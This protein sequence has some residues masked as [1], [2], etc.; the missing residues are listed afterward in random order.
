MAEPRDFHVTPMFF[1]TWG[2]GPY[3]VITQLCVWF[4]K[5][6]LLGEHQGKRIPSFDVQTYRLLLNL[7]TDH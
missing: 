7:E 4:F 3:R 5:N 1:R 6:R 2:K